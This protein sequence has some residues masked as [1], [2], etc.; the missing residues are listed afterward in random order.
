MD[1][2]AAILQ[3]GRRTS[4]AGFCEIHARALAVIVAVLANR[5]SLVGLVV[6]LVQ[7]VKTEEEIPKEAIMLGLLPPH[8]KT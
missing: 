1:Q 3:A 5:N 2:T 6:L 8:P 4:D 7:V